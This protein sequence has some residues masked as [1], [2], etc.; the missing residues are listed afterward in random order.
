[1]EFTPNF[2]VILGNTVRIF[3]K[4]DGYQALIALKE[5]WW[6]VSGISLLHSIEQVIKIRLQL[7]DEF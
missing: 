7:F 4:M 6:A 1:M 2:Q 5:I 3:S